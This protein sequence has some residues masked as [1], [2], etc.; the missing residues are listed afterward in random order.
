MA[1]KIASS[2]EPELPCCRTL[3]LYLLGE[4]SLADLCGVLINQT[5]AS[6]AQLLGSELT[7]AAGIQLMIRQTMSIRSESWDEVLK[8]SPDIMQRWQQLLRQTN[9]PQGLCLTREHDSGRETCPSDESSRRDFGRYQPQ[10]LLGKGGFGEVYL[11]YDPELD[12][13]VAIKTVLL[14]GEDGL[15]TNRLG[16]EARAAARL[17]HPGIVRVF[18]I[19]QNEDNRCYIVMEYIKGQSLAQLLKCRRPTIAEA[20]DWT[21][22]IAVALQHAHLHRIIHRDLKP[23][24]VLIGDDHRVA[25]TDFGLA[26]A[27]DSAHPR[28]KERAGTPAYMSPEQVNGETHRLDGRSD[29]WGLGVTMY[30]MFTGRRPFQGESAEDIFRDILTREPKPPRQVNPEL[31]K[32]LEHIC[33]R[34]LVRTMAQRYLSAADLIEDIDLWQKESQQA[35]GSSSSSPS[36][37]GSGSSVST[38]SGMTS[39]TSVVPKGLRSFDREDAD[40]F[41][42]LLPGPRDR[43][44]LPEQ[45]RF[46]KHCLESR[47]ELHPV[48]LLYGPSGCG[49]SSLVNAGI[50]PLLSGVRCHYVEATAATTERRIVSVLVHEYSFLSA[51]WGLPDCISALRQ[52]WARTGGKTIIVIDQLEQWMQ[53][54]HI[55]A[56]TPLVQALRQCDGRHVQAMLLVRDDF[57]MPTSDLMQAI[58]VPISDGENAAAI[59]PFSTRHARKVL[60]SFGRAFGAIDPG[61]NIP[62]EQRAFI[63]KAVEQL[64]DD[65]T[66]PCVHLAIFAE[67]MK[68]R[69]W[70]L[71]E[72]RAVGGAKGVGV[73]F[74][75][76]T[77]SAPSASAKYRNMEEPATRILES[78]LP[79]HG[80][81]IKGHARDA[82][83]LMALAALDDP[84]EFQEVMRCLDH[85]LRIISATTSSTS[86]ERTPTRYQ[87]THD[88]LVGPIREWVQ[89]KKGATWKGRAAMRLDDLSQRW[90]DESQS[91]RFLPSPVEYAT[92]V[93]GVRSRQR[94]PLAKR[95]MQAAWQRYGLWLG[96][97]GLTCLAVSITVW[98]VRTK[99]R[100]QLVRQRVEQ[101]MDARPA[102]VVP[103]L[104]QLRPDI[105][106][107]M[108][109][110]ERERDDTDPGQRFR[111]LIS[112]MALSDSLREPI[113]TL[114]QLV[115]SAPP[116][117]C[118]NLVAAFRNVPA[119]DRLELRKDWQNREPE[120]AMRLAVIFLYLGDI[121]PLRELVRFRADPKF[122]TAFIHGMDQWATEFESFVPVLVSETDAA[123]LSALCKSLGRITPN[124]IAQTAR[125]TCVSRFRELYATSP[126]ASVHGASEWA[127]R[128]WGQ[129]LDGPLAA[130][131]GEWFV[132]RAGMTL[133]RVPENTDLDNSIDAFY[134]SDK[135]VSNSVFKEFVHELGEDN[136]QFKALASWEANAGSD[137]APAAFVTY[138]E[139]IRF[140]NWLSGHEGRQPY[141]QDFQSQPLDEKAKSKRRRAMV[142]ETFEVDE[143]ADGYRLPDN[144]QFLWAAQAGSR[145]TTP[146]GG[147]EA[148][149]LMDEYV[150]YIELPEGYQST[151][152]PRGTLMP[153]DFGLFDTLGNAPEWTTPTQ[154]EDG[155]VLIWGTVPGAN[156]KSIASDTY[157]GVLPSAIYLQT[158]FRVVCP[159]R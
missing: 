74:L 119:E 81:R 40:F 14:N 159:T 30:E 7:D 133:V 24:N 118:E 153:N 156:R 59:H 96:I 38:G 97:L 137:D 142:V 9:P 108:P 11:A 120:A 87:L 103:L 134:M 141:Y 69:P 82:D 123:M 139:A 65:D 10:K 6:C 92:F 95:F 56:T 68:S 55:D 88:F 53:G 70:V 112:L 110:L 86:R 126:Y 135:E 131:V 130:G 46:W 111:A 77:F 26:Y 148:W 125:Q 129:L 144:R 23:A 1:D 115:T 47:S 140:C 64:S 84:R 33:L 63:R 104:D 154:P 85:E 54:R 105:K 91:H 3:R 89:R 93:A 132:N 100:M 39:D 42:E 157:L 4:R 78:L 98:R 21:R 127:L 44:G 28:R 45:V 58:E 62:S 149:Q 60:T 15:V 80:L 155:K 35:I 51:D 124:R 101:I 57:W 61:D 52:Q 48:C 117:E 67:M 145:T 90:N 71:R 17:D 34:C 2:P 116:D 19:V 99:Q 122:R 27:E 18:D 43:L 37:E 31:P 143:T 73:A 29:L 106:Y 76:Q 12:R 25:V 49:K 121:E 136:P 22:Q 13:Q 147:A 83:A 102:A 152:I 5:C 109:L 20:V 32:Q 158:G 79:D 151:L 150:H 128:R 16:P 146:V 107:A 94:S 114:I 50:V 75:E 138:F 72:L 8:L 66:V 41:L 113:D 36:P